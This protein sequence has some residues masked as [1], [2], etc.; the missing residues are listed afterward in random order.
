MRMFNDVPTLLKDMPLNSAI[1]V[2]VVVAFG[3]FLAPNDSSA[4]AVPPRV[5]GLMINKPLVPPPEPPLQ[6]EIQAVRAKTRSLERKIGVTFPLAQA[7]WPPPKPPSPGGVIENMQK[8]IN[9][10]DARVKYLEGQI[11]KTKRGK[12]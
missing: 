4:Q 7:N 2:L 10:L 9:E 11:E 5:Q 3:A 8:K 12:K 6:K 1:L